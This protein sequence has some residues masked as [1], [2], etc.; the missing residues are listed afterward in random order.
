MSLAVVVAYN[1][2]LKVAEGDLRHTWKDDNIVDF[3][4]FNYLHSNKMIKYNPTHLKYSCDT[5]MRP[6]TQHNQA[7][8]DKSK[9]KLRVERGSPLANEVQFSKFLKTIKEAKYR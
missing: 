3:W 6:Y 8:R 5:N 9:D 4:T 1:M 2:Y 7:K